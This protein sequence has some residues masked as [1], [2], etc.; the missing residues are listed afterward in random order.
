M[1]LRDWSRA[2]LS[3]IFP[4]VCS[5]CHRSLVDGEDFLCLGCLSGLPRT[6][7]HA[8]P[9]NQIH[10]RLAMPGM[11]I[12]R[13]G[14]W[15][16]YIRGSDFRSIVHDA[17]YRGMWSICR[18]A[19][20]TYARE[21]APDGFFDGIDM[22]VPIPLHRSRFLSRGYNQSEQIALG[23]S[24]V[25]GIPVG[26]CLQAV[27]G[28]ESQTRHNATERLRNAM[29]IYEVI[30]EMKPILQGKHVL[31]VD[32]V[33]TTG[34]TMLACLKAIADAAPTAR[35]SVMSLGATRLDG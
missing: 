34:A 28:H 22:I 20:A 25:T 9:F 17:K 15:F 23:V 13:A 35:L 14:A 5:V 29:G 30:P 19:A 8:L 26:H 31:I 6:N 18:R 4:D 33:I 12:E 3:M 16:W 11:L 24:D 21:I 32:D 10:E 27:C 2:L 1:A 7:I